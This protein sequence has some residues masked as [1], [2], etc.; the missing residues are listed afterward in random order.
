MSI[1]YRAGYYKDGLLINGGEYISSRPRI[2]YFLLYPLWFPL[3]KKQWG[4]RYYIGWR[5]HG[6]GEFISWWL[7]RLNKDMFYQYVQRMV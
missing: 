4:G 1:I 2:T 7:F 3:R 6:I 5:S